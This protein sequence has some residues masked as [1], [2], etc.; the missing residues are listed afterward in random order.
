M[1][2]YVSKDFY[3]A[4][5]YATV[6]ICSAILSSIAAF[7]GGIYA[8]TKKNIHVT[9]T[10]VIGA[11]TNIALNAILIPPIGIMGA[12]IATYFS[13]M[14]IA[15]IRLI[16]VYKLF[17]FYING[18]KLLLYTIMTVIQCVAVLLF[19]NF[20]YIVSACIITIMLFI[21]RDYILKAYQ[22]IRHRLN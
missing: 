22:S 10:T 17:S 3:L 19:N 20:S 4:W 1:V 8:A 14:I 16:D 11:I 9:V 15:I 12:A 7:T 21:E 5:K 6:L 13:W 18:K 2:V